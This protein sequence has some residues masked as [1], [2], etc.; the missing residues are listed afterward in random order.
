MFT[1][2]G[3][4]LA[5]FFVRFVIFTF[6]ESPKFLVYRG[7]DEEAIKVLEHIAKVNKRSCGITLED[8][9]SLATTPRSSIHSGTDMLDG[10]RKGATT[11]LLQKFKAEMLRY[12]LLFNG[13]QMTRLTLLVWL[14]YMM[15]F[16][17]F[18]LAG[19]CAHTDTCRTLKLF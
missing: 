18:T 17:G 6:Q 15:D 2:G 8:F 5:V 9:E 10:H 3:V 4:T 16:W 19:I 13:W 1:L 11:T 7:R 14:T 12:G